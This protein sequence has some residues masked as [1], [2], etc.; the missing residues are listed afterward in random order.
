[1]SISGS[2]QST[3]E[4]MCNALGI[5]ELIYDQRFLNNRLRI[6]NSKVLDE[7]LQKAILDFDQENLIQLFD[8][9][10]A[11]IAACNNIAEIFK[12]KH[13]KS[14]KNIIEINDDEL[15]GPIK[16]QNIVGNFSRTPGEIKHAGPKLG[17]HNVEVLINQLGFSKEE[18]IKEGYNIDNL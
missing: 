17:Q 10:G 15:G 11:A 9:F 1:M 13:I 5:K 8:Q 12:D 14:R 18:L 16:M 2:A 3:F 6:K 4:R 7:V